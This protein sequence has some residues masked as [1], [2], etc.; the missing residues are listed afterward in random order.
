MADKL[1]KYD[2]AMKS[3]K[4]VWQME[5]PICYTGDENTVTFDFNIIDLEE[6]DLVG[7]IPNVY[8][9]MRDGSFFQNGPADGVEITGTTVN[10]TMK[11][12]E[13]KH[14]GIAKAQLV[15]VWDDEVNPPEKLTSQMYAFEVVSGLENKVAVEVMIQDWTTLT[16]EARTFIDTSADEVDALKGELQTAIT[17]ANTSLGEFDVALQNGIV[18]TN[19]A[20][21]L[22]NLEET[23][24]PDLFTVKKQLE[25]TGDI[26]WDTP[27][28]PNTYANTTMTAEQVKATFFDKYVTSHPHYVTKNLLGLDESGTYQIHEYVFEPKNYEQTIVI[29]SGMHGNEIVPP[30]ALA[31]II[32][33]MMETPNIHEGFSYLRNKVKLVIIPIVN[34]WGFNQSPRKYG[35]VNGINPSR[36]WADGWDTLTTDDVADAWNKKGSAPF[37]EAETRYLRDVLLREKE[38]CSFY[39]D[40]HTAQGWSL[41]RLLYILD[42]DNYL[43]PQLLNVVEW[44][45]NKIREEYNREPVN[46]VEETARAKQ[47]YYP[48]RQMGIPSACIE[49]DV[50]RFGGQPN[51]TEDLTHYVRQLY[52]YIWHSLKA[53][54]RQRINADKATNANK[55]V[56]SFEKTVSGYSDKFN[57]NWTQDQI[58]ANFY[59]PLRASDTTYITRT[60][61]G[62]DASGLYDVWK[63]EL[64][65]PKYEKTVLL[66]SGIRGTEFKAQINLMNLLET[67]VTSSDPAIAELRNKVKFVIVPMVNPWGFNGL[68]PASKLNFNGVDLNNDFYSSTPQTETT[69]I[70]NLLINTVFDAAFYYGSYYNFDLPVALKKLTLMR[71]ETSYDATFEGLA[72]VVES[73]YGNAIDYGYYD[74]TLGHGDFIGYLCSVE[75]AFGLT[76]AGNILPARTTTEGVYEDLGAEPSELNLCLDVSMNMLKTVVSELKIEQEKAMTY[77][78]VDDTFI[79]P[80]T[81]FALLAGTDWTFTPTKKGTLCVSVNSTMRSDAATNT[82]MLGINVSQNS[83]LLRDPNM[84]NTF[85]I[86]GATQYAQLPIIDRVKVEPGIAVT[87]GIH[88][89][90]SGDAKVRRLKVDYWLE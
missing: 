39:L 63:Y 5:T 41:D 65:P 48:Q 72:N 62:K 80:L 34:P 29:S 59:E 13:G 82:V 71:M 73:K 54:I 77:S 43:R 30:F 52:N 53:N 60:S 69:Y 33:Y 51:G 23:Y 57:R 66:I 6:A 56:L 1:L 84:Y 70:K 79:V 12:N 37:S 36:N 58:I 61:L 31:K 20:A 86:V 10:Y 50:S 32:E 64:T 16:R 75:K 76:F 87:V 8:L 78:A 67:V 83:V 19:I 44:L 7:V 21:E 38:Q 88:G 14:S 3:T 74:A 2:V 22:Q 27:A 89:K 11:G 55:N 81:N 46:K 9:Y 45:D 49:H 85:T 35:N 40:C 28:Q 4:T 24:A 26:F 18:A 47:I 15:L 42:E 17:T 90:A 68:A 25:Q